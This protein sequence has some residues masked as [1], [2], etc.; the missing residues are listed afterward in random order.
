MSWI[1]LY[2]SYIAIEEIY[3]QGAFLK[4]KPLEISFSNKEIPKNLA[5]SLRPN[6]TMQITAQAPHFIAKI[7]TIGLIGPS[8]NIKKIR[9][10]SKTLL[11]K[12]KKVRTEN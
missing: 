8:N 4:A 3:L 6:P 11:F 5:Q 7:L 1:L 9:T 10:E 2:W 12:G